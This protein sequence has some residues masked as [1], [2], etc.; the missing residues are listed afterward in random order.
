MEKLLSLLSFDLVPIKRPSV[1]LQFNS[2]KLRVNQSV[3]DVGVIHIAEKLK[4]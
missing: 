3:R 2:R 1:L 4:R